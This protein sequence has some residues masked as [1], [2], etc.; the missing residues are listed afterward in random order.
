MEHSKRASDGEL[1]ILDPVLIKTDTNEYIRIDK[2]EVRKH[3][4]SREIL[5]VYIN[6]CPLNACSDTFTKLFERFLTK[7]FE[8]ARYDLFFLNFE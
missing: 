3:V 6:V 5:C 1:Q 7:H 4:I 8:S 2:N